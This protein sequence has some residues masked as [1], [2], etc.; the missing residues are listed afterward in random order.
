MRNRMAEDCVLVHCVSSCRFA[1]RYRTANL[2]AKAR[3]RSSARTVLLQP[4]C[5]IERE[6]GEDRI[7]TRAL[8]AGQGFEHA[9]TLIEPA[10]LRG[11]LEHRVLARDLIHKGRRAEAILYA[12]H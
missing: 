12:A 10:V 4:L 9:G 8:D 5:R 11:G 2:R 6:I 1:V 7:G 3:L